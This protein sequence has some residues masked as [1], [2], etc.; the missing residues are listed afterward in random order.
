MQGEIGDTLKAI[1][2]TIRLNPTLREEFKDTC[3]ANNTTISKTLR[4]A[5][6]LFVN[7]VEFQ[8]RIMKESDR[9]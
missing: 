8:Q 2:T 1:N 6:L 3:K 4:I 5:V 7:D 9:N